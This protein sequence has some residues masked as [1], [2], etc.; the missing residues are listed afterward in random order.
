MHAL[1]FQSVVAPNGIVNLYG[2]VEGSRHDS[3]MLAELNLLPLLQQHCHR[4]NGSPFCIYGDS[5]YLLRA[6]PQR[7]FEA[8]HL[9]QEQ[10]D[11]NK[12]M[13]TVRVSVE[14][15]FKEIIKYLAFMDFKQTPEDT[16]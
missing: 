1:K 3:G 14:W 16:T 9:P 2:P 11:F 13:K 10:K 5:A 15:V 12:S 4:V 7:P 6:H 8:N